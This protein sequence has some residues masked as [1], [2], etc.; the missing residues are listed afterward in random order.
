M[1][2]N[3]PQ[4]VVTLVNTTLA[5][6]AALSVIAAICAYAINQH[7]N[8]GFP[9]N[10]FEG[11]VALGM[12][13]TLAAPFFLIYHQVTLPLPLWMTSGHP[14][15]FGGLRPDVC[16]PEGYYE[17]WPCFP[18]YLKDWLARVA[19]GPGSWKDLSQPDT[20][21]VLCLSFVGMNLLLLGALVYQLRQP[22]QRR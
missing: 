2:E 7:L 19:A 3:V 5:I 8:L 4:E 9:F 15:S 12:V 18:L 14:I 17:T 10:I 20:R 22:R 6:D 11:V 16:T 21:L 13:W 1:S